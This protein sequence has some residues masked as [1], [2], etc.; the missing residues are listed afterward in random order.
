LYGGSNCRNFVGPKTVAEEVTRMLECTGSRDGPMSGVHATL[1]QI[2]ENRR[3]PYTG[4]RRKQHVYVR[5]IW[6]KIVLAS[7]VLLAPRYFVQLY[8]EFQIAVKKEGL[9]LA[10]I[11]TKR[12]LR[13]TFGR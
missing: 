12:Y 4:G 11:R 6:L 9:L 1:S 5:F 2:P 8:R 13:R 10:A 7:T 3:S